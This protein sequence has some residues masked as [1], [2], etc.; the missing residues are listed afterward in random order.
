MAS[1]LFALSSD[2]GS[3]Y[4]TAGVALADAT[5]L[6]YDAAGSYSIKAQLDSTAGVSAVLWSITSADDAHNAS[7]PTVTTNPDRTCE[8]SVPKQG[9]A[10]LLQCKVNGGVDPAT[11]AAST[12]LTRAL[13]IKV[14]NSNGLQEIAVGETTEAGAY[15]WTK[16]VNDGQRAAGGAPS[17]SAG[18]DLSGTYPNPTVA[19]LVSVPATLTTP[20]SAQVLVIKDVAGVKTIYLT[21]AP[22]AARGLF[23]LDTGVTDLP[24]Y[25]LELDDTI[26]MGA[27]KG[28]RNGG[29]RYT[30]TSVDVAGSGTIAL[31]NANMQAKVIR[32]TGTLTGDRTVTLPTGTARNNLIQNTATGTYTLRVEGFGGGFCYL[33]PGQSKHLFTDPTTGGALVGEG[34]R[35][36]EFT[37]R[38][39]ISGDT[40]GDHDTT[41]LKLPAG[42][43][44]TVCEIFVDAAPATGT[45][46]LSIGMSG[47][48][49]ELLVATAA[50]AAG[51]MIG[52]DTAEAGADFTGKTSAYSSVAETLVMRNTVGTA[53]L[54]AGAVRVHIVAVYKG[55]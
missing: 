22:G 10:W 30:T 18:G 35:V 45:A 42:C 31:T 12:T 5:A 8:F 17:G 6:A 50:T 29:F 51:Q 47:G 52:V 41:L 23:L 4:G 33:A 14:L 39:V 2:G 49:D 48:Y 11:G 7:L 21:T 43:A 15:G 13:A 32:L 53:T 26:E 16:A 1:A 37:Q 9:G 28:H 36:I 40:V 25:G 27:Y 55:E 34:L 20:A 24:F 44:V 54:T 3:T 19:K 38:I 46:T